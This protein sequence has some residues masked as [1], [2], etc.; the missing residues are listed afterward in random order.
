MQNEFFQI[1][2][3][4]LELC[5]VLNVKKQFI[6]NVEKRAEFVTVFGQF[7][8]FHLAYRTWRANSLG[9]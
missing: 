4:I 7:D 3:E 2:A 8:R 1:I 6:L 5:F 9:I